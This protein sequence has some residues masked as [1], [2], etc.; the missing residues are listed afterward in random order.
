MTVFKDIILQSFSEYRRV[1]KRYVEAKERTNKINDLGLNQNLSF[2]S[3]AALL[4]IAQNVACDMQSIFDSKP[5]NYYSYS[6]IEQFY[7]YLLDLLDQYTILN[8]Q[9]LHKKQRASSALLE[10]I[11]IYS[12]PL[13][14]FNDRTIDSLKNICQVI[15]LCADKDQQKQFAELLLR[16]KAKE[17][18]LFT[19]V[20]NYYS[21]LNTDA[22]NS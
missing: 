15:H 9:V 3:D 10:A 8:Q 11:Q 4:K 5:K 19:D 7:Q 21:N 16:L 6:G 2:S 14:K 22:I 17:E 20:C 12:Q 1:L 18:K 13:E